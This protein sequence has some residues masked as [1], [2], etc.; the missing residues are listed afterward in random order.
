LIKHLEERLQ[1]LSRS[2]GPAPLVGGKTGIEKE[3]LRVTID[4]KI[5][6]KSHP[7]ELGSPLTHPHITTDYSEALLEFITPPLDDPTEQLAFLRDCHRFAYQQM[8]D[9]LL[10][11]TSMPCIVGGEASIPIARYGDSNVGRMKNIYRRGLGYRYGRLM[12]V[13]AGVH[14]N[15]SP[16]DHF[17]SVFQECEKDS[18]DK[19]NF[20]S[21][22]YFAL[23]RNL[24]RVG[25]LIPYLFGASPA[26]CKSFLEGRTSSLKVLGGHSFYEPYGTSLRMSEIGYKNKTPASLHVGYDNLNNYL[27]DLTE[28]I[29]TRHPE[30]DEIGVQ[31][32]GEYRQLNANVLQI[33]NEFYGITRPKQVPQAGEKLITALRR[34]GVAYVEL[35]AL[36]VNP[37]LPLGI[38]ENQIRFL[39]MLM[40]FCLLCESL[41]I[42]DKEDAIIE[43]NQVA[44]AHRGRDPELV[45]HDGGRTRTVREWG[46]EILAAMGLLAEML[47]TDQA[48]RPY[49]QALKQFDDAIAEPELTPSARVLAEMQENQE[50]FF[51]FAMRTS[52]S[53]RDRFLGCPLDPAQDAFFQN[54]SVRS[55]DQQRDIEADDKLSFEE[56]LNDYLART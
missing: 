45:L 44:V 55:L 30:Y 42:G 6:Q 15:Y 32:D 53:H 8:D 10:W 1:S 38:D 5:S 7:S 47:D 29:T 36:D 37:F 22:S 9:E 51:R 23:I 19:R 56:Y 46:G 16:P 24:R 4:G 20:V 39:E 14:F 34:R 2:P 43:A 52:L 50:P 41:P 21:N 54:L 26:I 17:W 25:W 12:Q 28:A 48:E 11:A 35:R 3:S 27:R 49:G 40:L 31:V 33:E 13:I 18:G